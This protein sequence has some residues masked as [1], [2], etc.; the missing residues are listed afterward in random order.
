MKIMQ[1]SLVFYFFV[2][3]HA[4]FASFYSTGDSEK[5]LRD[6]RLAFASTVQ[7]NRQEEKL[8]HCVLLQAM[9]EHQ[10]RFIE[11]DLD[12]LREYDP[13]RWQQYVNSYYDQEHDCNTLLMQAVIRSDLS[14]IDL[15]RRSGADCNQ[16]NSYR[17]TALH[18]ALDSTDEQWRVHPY[19][20]S[21]AS[22]FVSAT[23]DHLQDFKDLN[24]NIQDCNRSSPLHIALEENQDDAVVIQLIDLFKVNLDLKN[25]FGQTAR[26]IAEQKQRSTVIKLLDNVQ[27]DSVQES[28]KQSSAQRIRSLS[29]NDVVCKTKDDSKVVHQPV[30]S[31]CVRP[32]SASTQSFIQ[33]RTSLKEKY[34]LVQYADIKNHARK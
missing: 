33:S 20:P 8:V 4:S 18:K 24:S 30:I 23:L 10:S 2:C 12:E 15:L 17:K 16:V 28:K 26:D 1:F 22:W 5:S 27:K 19:D 34:Y 6:L 32:V 3:C 7:P 29:E 31:Q 25:K 21:L 13:G 14:M 11:S 9:R